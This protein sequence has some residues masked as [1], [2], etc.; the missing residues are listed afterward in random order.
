MSAFE[1]GILGIPDVVISKIKNRIITIGEGVNL[2]SLLDNNF[3][4]EFIL[5]F[6][7]TLAVKQSSKLVLV[8]FTN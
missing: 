3:H 4:D 6:F 7:A 5:E 2:L 8:L 1:C